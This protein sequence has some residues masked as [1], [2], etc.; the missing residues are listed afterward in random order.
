MRNFQSEN[1]I[2]G[3]LLGFFR[4]VE[5]F[6]FCCV[7]EIKSSFYTPKERKTHCFGCASLIKR[8]VKILVMKKYVIFFTCSDQFYSFVFQKNPRSLFL[9]HG[10]L[11]FLKNIFVNS[12]KNY[13]SGLTGQLGGGATQ[14][15]KAQ[16]KYFLGP[17]GRG[18]MHKGVIKGGES[19][20][21]A[22]C[23]GAKA[24]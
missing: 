8:H 22:C 13:A 5:F 12:G 18:G 24:T 14:N 4:K 1:K 16:K 23:P 17:S 10:V 7:L 19:K 9:K 15:M 6:I 20:M 3:Y 21:E 2:D 11:F